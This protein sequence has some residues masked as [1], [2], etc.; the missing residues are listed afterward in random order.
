MANAF[1]ISWGDDPEADVET[2][3]RAS[4]SAPKTNGKPKRASARA[5]GTA[6]ARPGDDASWL[7]SRI[8]GHESIEAL[9]GDRKLVAD[10]QAVGDP[11]QVTVLRRAWLRR[12][13]ALAAEAPAEPGMVED[14]DDGAPLSAREE[15]A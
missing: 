3:K 5:K 11:K 1:L 6:P 8:E 15:R 4:E 7:A 12:E 13:A 14:L 9:R 2:D 10:L